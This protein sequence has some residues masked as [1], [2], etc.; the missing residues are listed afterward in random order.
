ML[1]GV[2]A[3]PK[4][5]SSS[6]CYRFSVNRVRRPLPFQRGAAAGRR[7][8]RLGPSFVLAGP[9]QQSAFATKHVRRQSATTM[10]K[11]APH[12]RGQPRANRGFH[13]SHE[14][15]LTTFDHHKS[16]VCRR[17][18][19]VWPMRPTAEMR[20]TPRILLPLQRVTVW[21]GPL[22][23]PP[24]QPNGRCGGAAAESRLRS[25]DRQAPRPYAP[26]SQA[27]RDGC[28]SPSRTD[29]PSSADT[30]GVSCGPRSQP[31]A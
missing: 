25:S 1:R 13:H 27:G 5:Q 22:P 30:R 21:G 3:P 28:A 29:Q 7:E 15:F 9:H 6:L 4:V 12:R 24:G 16:T 10:A 31:S 23:C 26:E 20:S 19:T 8:P 2:D 18:A 14:C 11:Y 17:F